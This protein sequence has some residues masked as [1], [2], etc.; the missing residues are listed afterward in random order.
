MRADHCLVA[1]ALA[2]G[3]LLATS[4]RASSLDAA[5]P[6]DSPHDN[7][8]P[9]GLQSY[10]P[11]AF[12]YTKNSDDV[13][14]FNFKLS[15]QYPL[16]P[17]YTKKWWG[18][19]NRLMFAFTGVFGFYI[20]DRPSSPVV[21]KEYNPQFFWQHLWGTSQAGWA[22]RLCRPPGYE[23]GP[24][25]PNTAS[26]SSASSQADQNPSC[27]V[28][29][30]YNHDSNGQIIDTPGAYLQTANSQGTGAANNAISRGWDYIGV[31]ARFIPYWD[32]KGKIS[33]YPTLRYFLSD[34]LLQGKP[35]ELHYWESLPDGKPRKEVDGLSLLAK[36]TRHLFGP[37]D[38][39]LVLGYTTGYV[40]AFRYSTVRAEVGIKIL[41]L[42]IVAWAQRGYMSD[43]SQ[44]Y[45]NVTGY[46]V[47]VE[48]GAF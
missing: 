8:L 28:T 30:G 18:Q 40:D 39:K 2:L 15:V 21:G 46:G 41:E 45:R 38:S 48:I 26:S 23:Q 33:V 37:V 17:D 32:V 34:G 43:L 16:M 7:W 3:A 4:V 19:Q 12:G 29:I 42:P 35:E 20:G 10:E 31:T 9:F 14:Y 47:Q 13:H 25:Y 22:G 6:A 24:T 11:S 44:Y 5:T 36:Y 1:C 27:Y